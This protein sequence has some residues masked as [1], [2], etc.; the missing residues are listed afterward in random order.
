MSTVKSIANSFLKRKEQLFNQHFE[1]TDSFNFSVEYSLLVE[2]FIRTLAGT[3]R[4]NF[5]LASAGSFSR[6]ELSPYSDIDLIFIAN[7]VEENEKDISDLVKIFWDSG[8]E[9]SHTVRDF[10]D[11]DKYL[12][13][14]LHT[15]TQF[16]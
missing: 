14:D 15:F 4:Y 13:T 3:K 7:S 9:V 8:I 16:I 2:E 1:R 10:N 12:L 11:I 5:I 6:R